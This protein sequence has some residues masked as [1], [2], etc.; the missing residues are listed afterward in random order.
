M[1]KNSAIS[2]TN[3]S[4]NPHY[5]CQKISAGCQNCYAYRDMQRY[6]HL[7]NTVTRAKPATF[8]APLKW[9]EPAKVFTC[10][11]SD[12]FIENADEWRDTA[13]DIIRQTPHLTYQI[14]TKRPENI[15][16]RLPTDWNAGWPN[17]WLGVSVEST[18]YLWRVAYLENTPSVIKFVSYEPALEYVDF[19][20]Y[21]ID[22]LIA[23]GESGPDARPAKLDWF[24]RVRDDC[25]GFGIPFFYKQFGG[26]HKVD[27]CWGGCKLDGRV[28]HEFPT[29][30]VR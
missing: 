10:S 11:W 24:R 1:A 5:G 29:R 4:W 26:N 7:P 12:F 27:G 15:H 19:M 28:W 16:D 17:V 25:H 20:P 23:G 22:W 18:D 6:G 9:H 30:N 8:N 14:L 13:W 3:H 2:W 21:E